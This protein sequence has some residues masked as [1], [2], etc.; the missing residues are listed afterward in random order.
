MYWVGSRIE[1]SV[2]YLT[3]DSILFL[4]NIDSQSPILK[5]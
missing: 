2:S 4:R 1:F 5:Q 3:D